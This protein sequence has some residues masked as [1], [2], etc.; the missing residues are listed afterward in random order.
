MVERLK[1]GR[2]PD[3]DPRFWDG[4]TERPA[5]GLPRISVPRAY[6][7]WRRMQERIAVVVVLGV[8]TFLIVLVVGI[9]VRANRRDGRRARRRPVEEPSPTM[10]RVEADEDLIHADA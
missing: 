10:P 4:Y 3:T 8:P 2:H 1:R 7:S 6:A 9:A 5:P